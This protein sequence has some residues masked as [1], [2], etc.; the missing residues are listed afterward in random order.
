MFQSAKKVVTVS[1]G[2]ESGDKGGLPPLL[3]PQEY[4]PAATIERTMKASEAFTLPILIKR[5]NNRIFVTFTVFVDS[6]LRLKQP[7]SDS[8]RRKM[9]THTSSCKHGQSTSQAE[10][11]IVVAFSARKWL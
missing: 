10:R 9:E 2:D 4:K 1:S 3:P 11:G 7:V 8:H 6:W 5:G